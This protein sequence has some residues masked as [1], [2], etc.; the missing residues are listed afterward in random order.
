MKGPLGGCEKTWVAGV[1]RFGPPPEY[2]TSNIWGLPLITPTP[3]P[4]PD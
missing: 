1:G 2:A 3:T 4:Y